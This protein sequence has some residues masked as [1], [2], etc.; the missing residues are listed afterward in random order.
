MGKAN[1]ESKN[2]R[3][4]KR[5]SIDHNFNKDSSF[6]Y[7]DLDKST[8]FMKKNQFSSGHTRKKSTKSKGIE[9]QKSKRSTGKQIDE[10]IKLGSRTVGVENHIIKST[11]IDYNSASKKIFHHKQLKSLFNKIINND[12]SQNSFPSSSMSKGK[13]VQQSRKKPKKKTGK[14][15]KS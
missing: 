6:K 10:Q 12:L 3:S 8:K 11:N 1:D 7:S 4:R 5:N 14:L 9:I 13:V 2:K 15:N